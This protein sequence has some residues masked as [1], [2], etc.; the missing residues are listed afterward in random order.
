MFGYPPSLAGPDTVHRSKRVAAA[1]GLLSAALL[2]VAVAAIAGG[3]SLLQSHASDWLAPAA[4]VTGAFF[5]ISSV[6]VPLGVL[7]E[8][9]I[10][11]NEKENCRKDCRDLLWALSGIGDRTLKGLAW[12]NLKVTGQV[13]VEV[14]SL[15]QAF[16][17]AGTGLTVLL[18][19]S[20]RSRIAGK[21]RRRSV[22]SGGFLGRGGLSVRP[23]R[24]LVSCRSPGSGPGRARGWRSC[25]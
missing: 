13:S 22:W 3:G 2:V 4:F 15:R 5:F 9:A 18:V 21:R 20:A 11:A 19:T 14:R 10:E 24:G 7:R 1:A 23:C 12:I 25:G 17:L 6:V 16:S 8:S